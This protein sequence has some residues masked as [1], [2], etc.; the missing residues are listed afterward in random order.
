M[1]SAQRD[2]SDSDAVRAH[3]RKVCTSYGF[4]IG[5]EDFAHCVQ[6]LRDQRARSTS[7]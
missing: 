5:A 6:A 4:R 1:D 7:P 3:D 2:E